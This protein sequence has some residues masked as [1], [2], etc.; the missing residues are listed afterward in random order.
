MRARSRIKNAITYLWIAILLLSISKINSPTINSSTSFQSLST[1]IEEETTVKNGET[2]YL[3]SIL[4]AK[5]DS[6]ENGVITSVK[7]QAASKSCWAFAAISALESDCISQG[8]GTADNTDFSESHLIWF[9]GNSISPNSNNCAYN[10][11]VTSDDPYDEAGSWVRA[12]A[13]LARWSGLAKES[14]Y[15]FPSNYPKTFQPLKENDRYVNDSGIIIGSSEL[16]DDSDTDSIKRW[17]MEHGSV[18]VSLYTSYENYYNSPAGCAYFH[19][20]TNLSNHGL[21]IIGWDDTFSVD[22]FNPD[23]CPNQPGAWLCKDSQG[24]DWCDKGFFWVSYETESLNSFVGFT[25]QPA[26]RFDNNYTYNGYGWSG[27]IVCSSGSYGANVFT[28]NGSE[29]LKAVSFYT[30][31][32][33][34][35]VQINIYTDLPDNVKDPTLG[36]LKYASKEIFLHNSGYHT[37]DLS[38]DVPLSQGTNF[39]IVIRYSHESGE[40]RIP[41]EHPKDDR[42]FAGNKGESYLCLSDRGYHWKDARDYSFFNVCIQAFTQNAA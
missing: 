38:K 24:E 6:R 33:D 5:Y 26:E 41:I 30:Q 15:P 20:D 27:G 40:T 17:I 2:I 21:T 8:L 22:N 10:E 14:S 37:I 28:S 35:S 29:T 1:T 42:V 19:N 34:T 31:Q 3:S 13:A 23:C 16:L 25:C 9:S 7:S 39:S 32:P 18:V 11:G 36:Y 4:P 12:T